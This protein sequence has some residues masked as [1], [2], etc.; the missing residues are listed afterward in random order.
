MVSRQ[1]V[2][3][4]WASQSGLPRIRTR[5]LNPGSCPPGTIWA[6]PGTICSSSPDGTRRATAWVKVRVRILG[7]PLCDAPDWHRAKNIFRGPGLWDARVR[8][9]PH[10]VQSLLWGHLFI[11][12]LRV[13]SPGF[14]LG[15]LTQTVAL[16]GQ[17]PTPSFPWDDHSIIPRLL[18]TISLPSEFCTSFPH[19]LTSSEKPSIHGLLSKLSIP[20]G[21]ISWGGLWIVKQRVVG[22]GNSC[23]SL[24][25]LLRRRWSAFCRCSFVWREKEIFLSLGDCP[26]VA[27]QCFGG[28]SSVEVDRYL[29][30]NLR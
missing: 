17:Q 5:D 6:T 26:D 11:W 2:W 12:P 20:P 28:Y 8:R 10:R 13:T 24:H 19:S 15:T 4:W 23:K 30:Y 21:W 1:W 29:V 14:E 7:R 18:P 9:P 3:S 22:A 25:G 16:L 27:D